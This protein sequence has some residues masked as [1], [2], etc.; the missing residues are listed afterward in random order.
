[1][2]LLVLRCATDRAEDWSTRFNISM[3]VHTPSLEIGSEKE[4]DDVSSLTT[5]LIGLDFAP[6][7]DP[8]L[9]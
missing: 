1:M 7:L 9:L 3:N 6:G 5:S 2:R 8:I 4:V